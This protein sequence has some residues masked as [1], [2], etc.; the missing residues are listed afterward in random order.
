MLLSSLENA[1]RE[2]ADVV[3]EITAELLARVADLPAGCQMLAQQSSF[4]MLV[5]SLSMP[6]VEGICASHILQTLGAIAAAVWPD[7]GEEEASRAEHRLPHQQQL[8]QQQQAG[9]PATGL[10]LKGWH[11]FLL[12]ESA[13]DANLTGQMQIL[14]L[15]WNLCTSSV[16][17][18]LLLGPYRHLLS[19][20]ASLPG[21]LSQVEWRVAA[22]EGGQGFVF[23]GLVLFI[24]AAD[25]LVAVFE[26]VNIMVQRAAVIVR[27]QRLPKA[28]RE[29]WEA[30]VCFA[31]ALLHLNACRTAATGSNAAS[32]HSGDG[33]GYG[34]L[35]QQLASAV[36]A[37]AASSRAHCSLL[38]QL[39]ECEK[40]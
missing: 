26:G 2:H 14:L 5:R 7:L 1:V 8:Q 22:P 18:A 35:R 15:L 38:Q 34:V 12:V 29:L 28:W 10:L 23:A 3:A 33:A 40:A 37:L 25:E 20:M 11:V 31:Q 24:A 13:R 36:E 16:D 21:S 32:L 27:M 39:Q 4:D 17:H 9:H 30:L 19:K 6:N